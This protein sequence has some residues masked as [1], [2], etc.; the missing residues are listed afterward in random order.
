MDYNKKEDTIGDMPSDFLPPK[1]KESKKIGL[2][3][4]RAIYNAY[5]NGN[6]MQREFDTIAENRRYSEGT[7]DVSKFQ[8]QL[9]AEGD[10]TALNLDWTP[11][12]VISKFV[13]FLDVINLRMKALVFLVFS[14]NLDTY[15]FLQDTI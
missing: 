7:Y 15:Q 5:T 3:Y 1:V 14:M 10:L 6:S 8:N 11:V 2:Q 4:A 9:N 12:S 13:D